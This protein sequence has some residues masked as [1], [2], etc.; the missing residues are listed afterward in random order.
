MDLLNLF[1]K[2]FSKELLKQYRDGEDNRNRFTIEDL[3]GPAA[4]LEYPDFDIAYIN[5]SLPKNHN[6]VPGKCKTKVLLNGLPKAKI[7][8][9][10]LFK[11][12]SEYIFRGNATKAFQFGMQA[13]WSASGVPSGG[14][15]HVYSFFYFYHLYDQFTSDTTTPKITTLIKG[16]APGIEIP[17]SENKMIKKLAGKAIRKINKGSLSEG[18][19]LMREILP[20]QDQKYPFPATY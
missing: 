3:S 12:A 4:I 15:E 17:I 10:I 2:K 20:L 16:W 18:V 1:N 19:N 6:G 14:G 5:A 13:F 7:K 8:N 11:L 9:R